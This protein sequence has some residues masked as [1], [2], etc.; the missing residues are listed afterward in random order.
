MVKH[1]DRAARGE[2]NGA[3]T[4]PEKRC[5]GERNGC[6]KLTESK[7][8]EIRALQG[9]RLQKDIAAE[10]GVTQVTVSAIHLRKAWR[11]LK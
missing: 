2:R 4:H 7:V 10:Y 6:A 3:A 11:H 9:G 5:R 1:P 8:R